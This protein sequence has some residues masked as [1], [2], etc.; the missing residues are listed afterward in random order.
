[1][2]LSATVVLCNLMEAFIMLAQAYADALLLLKSLHCYSINATWA[3]LFCHI[4]EYR[5]RLPG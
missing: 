3:A 2:G 1:M 5:A 4:K